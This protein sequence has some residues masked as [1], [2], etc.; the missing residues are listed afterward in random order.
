MRKE[1]CLC[2]DIPQIELNTK[3]I[4]VTT[5]RE[6]KIP[7]NTGRL[8]S[9]ALT[10]S[11]ILIRGV[12][13]QPYDLNEHLPEGETRLLLYPCPDALLLTPELVNQIA[14]PINLIVPDGN[15]RQTSKMRRRDPVMAQIPTVSL[16]VGDTSRYLVRK[17]TK[18]EGLA[19]IEGIARALGIIES[20]A[21]QQQL[22][23][24]LGLMVMRTLTSRGKVPMD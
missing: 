6:L 17:E 20:P 7:T 21:I 5:K 1:L 9:L 8:A 12:E 16:P 15:W 23:Q 4:I 2:R 11:T 19:T 13:D 18:A 10:N 14:K 24:L 3:V 22:E